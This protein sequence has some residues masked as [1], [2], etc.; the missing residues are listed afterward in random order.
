MKDNVKAALLSAFVLPG[1]GQL[2][3]GK[4]L[5]GGVLIILVTIL[6][7]ATFIY[8]V[9][10][11]HGVVNAP[12]LPGQVPADT[13]AALPGRL[14]PGLRWLGGAFLCIWIYGVVDAL[15][16]RGQRDDCRSGK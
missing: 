3:R 11:V 12:K 15:L 14:K 1:V 6:L 13:F 2:Y 8:V 4:H 9:C 10:A 16:D 5:K 7:I